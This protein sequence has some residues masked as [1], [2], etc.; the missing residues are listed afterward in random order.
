[1]YVHIGKN[2]IINSDYIVGIFNI[3]T[4][5]KKNFFENVCKNLEIND[6]IIDISDDNQK[7]LI[8]IQK[9]EVTRGYITNIS[10]T[11][12]GKRTNYGGFNNGK[13]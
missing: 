13:S 2:V 8:I 4:L 3:E 5:K 10:S 9:N 11:T 12:L 1:M 7:S 6:K